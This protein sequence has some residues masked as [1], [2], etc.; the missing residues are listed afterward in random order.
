[1]FVLNISNSSIII[2]EKSKFERLKMKLIHFFSHN[3]ISSIGRIRKIILKCRI[4]IHHIKLSIHTERVRG[5]STQLV[6][7]IISALR[8]SDFYLLQLSA[9]NHHY[10]IHK[11]QQ[12]LPVFEFS[13]QSFIRI[14]HYRQMAWRCQWEMSV[15][16]FL[17]A[18]L[19]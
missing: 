6:F 15:I 14:S 3:R 4:T 13:K 19:L 11:Q 5:K 18:K 1:M 2:L 7:V 12:R 8:I 17:L 9:L 10:F 16:H